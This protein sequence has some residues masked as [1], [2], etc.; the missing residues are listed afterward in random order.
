LKKQ[1]LMLKTIILFHRFA[2][3]QIKKGKSLSD[4]LKHPVR[5]DITRMRYI[6]ENKLDD[7]NNIINKI[8]SIEEK[9]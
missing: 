1:Y 4:I 7:F 9:K 3:E 8:S 6:S 5:A 2:I